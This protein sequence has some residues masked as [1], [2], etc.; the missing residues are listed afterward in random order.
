LLNTITDQPT[1][2]VISAVRLN[3]KLCYKN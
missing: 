3:F 2:T 1:G